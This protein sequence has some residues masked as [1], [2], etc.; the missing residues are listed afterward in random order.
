MMQSRASA[1][2]VSM[3]TILRHKDCGKYGTLHQQ[4]EASHFPHNGLRPVDYFLAGIYAAMFAL[5]AWGLFIIMAAVFAA[6][7]G[8]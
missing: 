4:K 3:K 7:G 2:E 1:E 8:D 6:Y 5:G